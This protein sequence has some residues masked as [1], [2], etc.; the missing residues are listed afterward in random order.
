MT[1]AS[2]G[3]GAT[4]KWQV[5]AALCVL[6]LVGGIWLGRVAFF[7]N[8][9]DSPHIAQIEVLDDEYEVGGQVQYLENEEIYILSIWTLPPAPEGSVYQ[10]WMQ[11]GDLVVPAGV[12]NP[13]STKFSYAAYDGRYE[14]LFVTVEQAPFGVESPTTEPILEADLS[15]FDIE[16]DD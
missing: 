7:T 6:A 3:N 13:N 10:V 9:E 1:E 5:A 8:E 4:I 2:N 12:M 14:T 11:N 15:D 16:E